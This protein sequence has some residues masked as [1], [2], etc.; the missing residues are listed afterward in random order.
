MMNIKFKHAISHLA[1]KPWHT[2]DNS[3]ITKNASMSWT[4]KQSC[5]HRAEIAIIGVVSRGTIYYGYSI[6]WTEHPLSWDVHARS[7]WTHPIK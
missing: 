3:L 4:L 1:Y 2:R 6:C 5:S 7:F